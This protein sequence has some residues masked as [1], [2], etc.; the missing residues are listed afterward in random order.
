MADQ[1]FSDEEVGYGAPAAGWNDAEVGYGTEVNPISSVIGKYWNPDAALKP[2]TSYPDT[3]AKMNKEAREQMSHG[4]SQVT[5]PE[6][7]LDVA[8]GLG[9][10]ALGA[11]GYTTSPISAAYRT[12]IGQPIEDV[13]GIPKEYTEFA[14]GL[15]T[16]GLGLP[17]LMRT[18][19]PKV[20]PRGPL[21]VTLSEGQ[22]TGELSLIQREQAA[23]R[24]QTG[25]QA[26]R[27][28]KEFADQQAAQLGEARENVIR[29][30]DPYGQIITDSPQAAGELASNTIR[31]IAGQSKSR[32]GNLYDVAKSYPGEVDANVFGQVVPSI[33]TALSD[34]NDKV[35]IN[36]R[37]TPFASDA[38]KM[39]ED[40]VANLN[41]HPAQ[42]QIS[43]VTL[44]GIEQWRKEL[45]AYRRAA[46]QNNPSD[47]RA[48]SAVVDAFDDYINTAINSG[49]FNG[50]Q[51]AIQAWNDARSA[52]ADYMAT[53]R[54]G[55]N[56]QVGRQIEK[57]IGR[58]GEPGS[59]GN[60][61]ADFLFGVSGTNPNS[62]N[63]GVAR[64]VQKIMGP[65]S[66][67][68]ASVK[69]GLFQRLA[70][71]GEGVADFSP[72][73]VAD[74][75]NKFLNN[76]GVEMARTVYSP[77]ERDL[78][79]SYAD[80]MRKIEV[81]QSGANWSNTATAKI[82]QKIGSNTASMIGLALGYG[83]EHALNL[84]VGVGEAAGL[85]LTKGSK[86]LADA[87]EARA[88]AR[89]MPILANQMQVWRRAMTQS[90]ATPTPFTQRALQGAAINL[91]STLRRLG[92]SMEQMG[93]TL[94]GPAAVK[95]DPEQV[96]RKLE[97][98]GISAS[99][100]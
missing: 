52:H 15:A 67:E 32:V 44:E 13:T 16:P 79:Q 26:Q 23:L 58:G 72:K 69:Q 55:K 28:A 39:I 54:A 8:K 18:P 89:Q 5:S 91:D 64:R 14:A 65:D 88:I 40:K 66:P 29:S 83:A 42:N 95:A 84:P 98:A 3:Y 85:A 27:A 74:R 11:V 53:F 61:V 63:L 7:A 50:D 45:V 25:T 71:S 56:D 59:T 35:I 47:G 73:K 82:F 12:V 76:D 31:S 6:S 75:I 49:G 81:P 99:G 4:A 90:Q 78:L 57:I 30:L 51:R 21:G 86:Y 41:G 94:Q 20:P 2:I 68:W 24:G 1:G 92:M 36:D 100:L 60:D 37:L 34:P 70:E 87:R 96:K 17:R 19:V 9:N 80:L 48:A 10:M 93:M 97:A 33:K 46:W 38:I 77:A 62:L 22:A 43:G